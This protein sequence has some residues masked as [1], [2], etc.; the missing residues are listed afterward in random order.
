[1]FRGGVWRPA[2]SRM[3]LP[4]QRRMATPP[5]QAQMP[6]KESSNGLRYAQEGLDSRK[7]IHRRRNARIR[8]GRVYIVRCRICTSRRFTLR[9]QVRV[10]RAVRTLRYP[11]LALARRPLQLFRPASLTLQNRVEADSR[12]SVRLD[13]TLTLK[14]MHPLV[15]AHEPAQST[16][17]R[18]DDHHDRLRGS[19]SPVS[20]QRLAEAETRG[21]DRRVRYQSPLRREVGWKHGLRALMT[22]S[23]RDRR[24]GPNS[25]RLGTW[26]VLVYRHRYSPAQ[27]IKLPPPQMLGTERSQMM[28]Q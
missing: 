20:A 16:S 10:E 21:G 13:M 24:I 26:T 4:R 25:S 19:P 18:T 28:Q 7:Y 8:G 17:A 1:M 23:P 3:I 2:S 9:S 14:Y 22:M 27:G 6:M 12:I 11:M 15:P 5:F